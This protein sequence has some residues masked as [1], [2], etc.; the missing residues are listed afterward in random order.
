MIVRT[1]NCAMKSTITVQGTLYLSQGFLCFSANV[2][3][4]RTK[5][6][7]DFLKVEEI[8]NDKRTE[9]IE[10]L[11]EGRLYYFK[12]FESSMDE[13]YTMIKNFHEQK[14]EQSEKHGGGTGGGGAGG[15]GCGGGA[16][17]GGEG[18]DHEEEQEKDDEG[19]A[20]SDEDW[21]KILEGTR[22]IHLLK[23]EYVIREG[24]SHK[25]RL[26]QIAKGQCRIEKTV[27]NG[28]TLEFGTI[29]VNDVFGEI[30][31]LEGTGATASVISNIPDTV[32]HIID[33]Y[34]LDVLFDY[35]PGLSGRFY[36][37]LATV[38]SARLKTREETQIKVKVEKDEEESMEMDEDYE[39]GYKNLVSKAQN[40]EIKTRKKRKSSK[41]LA[42]GAEEECVEVKNKKNNNNTDT[43]STK[44]KKSLEKPKEFIEE[45]KNE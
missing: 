29:T 7:F 12:D 42:V 6:K 21:N 2:F 41:R 19:L 17:A 27:E 37:Y 18:T 3:G 11:Y 15:A 44:R 23:D 20:P 36:H 9:R 39:R 5:D 45:E 4:R 28:K 1:F 34:Y 14:K 33:G 40:D 13:V 38:L 22:S 31:F 35:Y 10:I 32:V 24:E 30:S 8:K 26:Y 16:G 43:N 25:Q